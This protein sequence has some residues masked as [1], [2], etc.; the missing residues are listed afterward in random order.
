[1][2]KYKN[3][4]ECIHCGAENPPTA[5]CCLRCFKVMKEKI[6]TPFWRFRIEPSVASLGV[7]F[8]IL[9]VLVVALK[10]WMENIDAQVTMNLKTAENSYSLVA[11]KNRRSDLTV[12]TNSNPLSDSSEVPAQKE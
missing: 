7:A 1:M 4:I 2:K 9:I 11:E 5:Y 8:A 12:E 6:K 10:H 3:L